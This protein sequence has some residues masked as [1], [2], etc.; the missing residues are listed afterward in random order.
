V[1]GADAAGLGIRAFRGGSP[2]PLTATEERWRAEAIPLA[3][4]LMTVDRFSV[5][6]ARAC[7]SPTPPKRI[8]ASKPASTARSC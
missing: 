1:R 5:E 4:A 8:D 6:V 2:T 7:R 3:I